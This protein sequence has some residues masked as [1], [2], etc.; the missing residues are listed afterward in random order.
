MKVPNFWATVVGSLTNN[1]NLT[2]NGVY[3]SIFNEEIKRRSSREG[4]SLM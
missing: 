2:F 3:G 1:P 4:S